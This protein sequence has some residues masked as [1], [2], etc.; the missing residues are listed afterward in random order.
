MNGSVI[1]V[2]D[3]MENLLG[4]LYTDMPVDDVETI[5]ETETERN[6]EF[7]L[8]DLI[9]MIEPQCT[10]VY[11]IWPEKIVALKARI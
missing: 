8:H 3:E 1:K 5:W 6:D 9:D 2:Y 11:R 4:Y 10:E 7:D